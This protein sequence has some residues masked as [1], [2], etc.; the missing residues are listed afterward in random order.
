MQQNSAAGD[1]DVP[2]ASAEYFRQGRKLILYHGFSDGDITPFRTTQ[3]YRSL[4]QLHGGY[5]V[6]QKNARLFMVP[7]MAHCGGGPGPNAFGQL[8][9]PDP[10][11]PD[12]DI[13]VA[14]ENWVEK[15]AAPQSIIATKF[16]HDNPKGPV[17]RTM[18]LCPFPA[19]ARYKGS[20]DIHAAANWSCPADDQ[21]LLDA[22]QAGR[23]AGANA[24]LNSR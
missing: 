23:A 13:L 22:G 18:P 8:W 14:L 5:A 1:G 19:M 7:G 17:L 21:R 16:D 10:A 4:A 3:Y 9:A 11:G 15:G 24:D 20:G 2:A 12:S 6:L